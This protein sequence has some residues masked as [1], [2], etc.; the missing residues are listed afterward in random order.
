MAFTFSNTGLDTLIGALAF[1]N[2]IKFRDAS[3]VLLAT[4]TVTGF[5]AGTTGQI[6]LNSTPVSTTASASGTCTKF[7]LCIGTTVEGSGTCGT[8]GADINFD[9]NIW[10]SGGAVSI[11]SLSV[12][13]S[14]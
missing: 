4:L 14:N 5:S 11:T 3:N 7:D 1:I 2:N 10:T 13:I 12:T 9:N 8:S 6:T